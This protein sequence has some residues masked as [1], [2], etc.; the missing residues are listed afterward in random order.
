M[1][2]TQLLRRLA[3]AEQRVVQGEQHATRQRK[4][5]VDQEQ[6]GRDASKARELLARFEEQQAMR[7]ADRDWLKSE[8]SRIST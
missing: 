6:D 5:V 4:V 1:D 2:Q 3:Q 7:V 8:L